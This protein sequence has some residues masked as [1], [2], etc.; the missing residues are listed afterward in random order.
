[1]K[2]LATPKRIQIVALVIVAAWALVEHVRSVRLS[3]Q[4]AVLENR[5]DLVRSVEN[6]NRRLRTDL[7][8]N[9]P[10]REQ[11]SG[12]HNAELLRLRGEVGVL[13]RQVIEMSTNSAGSRTSTLLTIDV[14]SP[15]NSLSNLFTAI[16]LADRRAVRQFLTPKSDLL[17]RMDLD[18]FAAMLKKLQAVSVY[19]S[20]NLAFGVS[21]PLPDRDGRT[22]LLFEVRNVDGQW[23]LHKVRESELSYIEARLQGLSREQGMEQILQQ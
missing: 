10:S 8:T 17:N 5:T 22:A 4:L 13:R 23:L 3:K 21:D 20:T 15:V 1:M 9:A 14:S 12:K 2:P 7:A 18:E 11:D 6:E 16:H 19:A